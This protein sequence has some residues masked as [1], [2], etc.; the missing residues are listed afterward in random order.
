[1]L[2][3]KIETNINLSK[4][5]P[6]ILYD[7][8]MLAYFENCPFLHELINKTFNI[9]QRYNYIMVLTKLIELSEIRQE[10]LKYL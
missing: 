10:V 1:M 7:G 6:C 8:R 4:I 3:Y 9:H 2:S 5:L